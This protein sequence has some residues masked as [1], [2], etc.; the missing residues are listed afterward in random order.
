MP[1]YKIKILIVDDFSTMRR[2]T[3]N[4]LRQLGFENTEEA[5]DGI[6]AFMK[7]KTEG[8]GFVISDWNM[9]NKDGLE[10]L[11]S[12]RAD[13]QLKDIPFLMVT[14]EAE[15]DKVIEAIKAGVNNYIVKPYTAEVLK[16]K[17]D[18]IFEKL[19]K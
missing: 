17:M 1:D 19:G 15:K 4:I 3:K 9:P 18:R 7:L 16:E 10:L 14:A 5:E 13:P 8:F 6:Q 12:V 11:K 2:I